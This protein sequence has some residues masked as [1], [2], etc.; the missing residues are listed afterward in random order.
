MAFIL[1]GH[2]R[3]CLEEDMPNCLPSGPKER[4]PR[5]SKSSADRATACPLPERAQ[6][7][8]KG[9]LAQLSV[10]GF[11]FESACLTCSVGSICGFKVEGSQVNPQFWHHTLAIN[12]G[13]ATVQR[14]RPLACAAFSKMSVERFACEVESSNV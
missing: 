10:P 5:I 14:D 3:G 7:P 12:P 1:L 2:E 11:A 8:R 9:T 6:K 4:T 13:K